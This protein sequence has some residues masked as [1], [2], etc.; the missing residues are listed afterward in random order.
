MIEEQDDDWDEP[1]AAYDDEPK[2][3]R[4]GIAP[5]SDCDWCGDEQD[6]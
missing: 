3:C 5:A 6:E 1:D 4:H 2:T